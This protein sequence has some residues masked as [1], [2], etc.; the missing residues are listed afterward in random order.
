MLLNIRY[1]A[2]ECLFERYHEIKSKHF[3][4]E[5]FIKGIGAIFKEALDENILHEE[6]THK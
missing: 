1:E 6:A 5:N 3:P 4:D 2:Y